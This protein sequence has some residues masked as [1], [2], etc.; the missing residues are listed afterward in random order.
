MLRLVK[1]LHVNEIGRD[2][3]DHDVMKLARV[4]KACLRA[5]SW[6]VAL[7]WLALW[8]LYSTNAGNAFKEDLS[9]HVGHSGFFGTSGRELSSHETHLLIVFT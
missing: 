2:D 5:A 4:C 6:A 3:D 8:L 1:L 9:V 7:W